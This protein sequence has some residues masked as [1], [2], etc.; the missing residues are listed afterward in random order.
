M[1]SDPQE[2]KNKPL[3]LPLLPVVVRDPRFLAGRATV[4]EPASIDVFGTLLQ[5]AVSKY[6]EA[7]VEAAPAYYEYGNALFR[8]AQRRESQP[9]TDRISAVD[10]GTATSEAVATKASEIRKAAADAAEC[11]ANAT[12]NNGSTTLTSAEKVDTQPPPKHHTEK[13]DSDIGP[14]NDNDD[15]ND[16]VKL[17]LEMMETAWSILDNEQQSSEATAT[18]KGAYFEWIKEQVPRVLTGIGDVLSALNRHADSADAYLRALGHRLDALEAALQNDNAEKRQQ[19]GD[20]SEGSQLLLLQCRRKVVEVNILIVEEL[21]ACGNDSDVIT[22]ESKAVL[23]K[24][25]SVIDYARGYYDK[26]RDELQEAVMLLGQLAAAHVDAGNEK[27]NICFVATM[28]MG[29]GTALME[30]DELAEQ[31]KEPIKKKAKA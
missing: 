24:A 25:G 2:H 19:Q 9:M 31:V 11:R 7:H 6:G 12:V 30:M 23:V 3:L 26:A 8:H 10:E 4:G 5:E 14:D 13:V 22:T 15:D 17:S 21:L 18:E 16:D 29:A 20:N 1:S 28:V 27:E